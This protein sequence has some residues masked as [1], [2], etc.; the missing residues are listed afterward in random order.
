MQFAVEVWSS[1]FEQVAATCI[2]AEELGLDGFYYGESP[3]DLNL[4]CW[5]TLAA[6]AQVTNTI[7]LG[8]VITN[9]LPTYRS[10][11]LLAKQ[12]A[13]V[14]AISAGRLDFRTGVG[15]SVI[16][17]RPWWE[18]N[19]IEYPDYQRRLED[20]E[21]ALGAL[22]GLWNDSTQEIPVTVAATGERAMRLAVEHGDVWETSFC[23]PGE[24]GERRKRMDEHV[25]DGSIV[26][27]LEVDGFVASSAAGLDRLLTRVQAERGS[28]EDLDPVMKRAVVGTPEVAAE[29]LQELASVGVDQVVVALHDP[30]EADA[31]EALAQAARIVRATVFESGP[32]A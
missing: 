20:L 31:L 2:K 25:G 27:S 24:F 12:A 3:H 4:D 17:G 30:H 18:P 22:P 1:D 5:T 11:V 15:A 6:L 14:A 21:V 13:T 9:V 26:S 10:T 23:T 16:Y 19:G 28:K 8:P 32:K 7:R 29:Q